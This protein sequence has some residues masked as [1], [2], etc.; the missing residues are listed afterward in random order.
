V[1]TES[2]Q[3]SALLETL[4]QSLGGSWLEGDQETELFART[5][6][7]ARAIGGIIHDAP[8]LCAHWSSLPKRAIARDGA[9][10]G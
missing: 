1:R 3:W 4:P 9:R 10:A 2:W 8:P 7:I 5:A 6:L